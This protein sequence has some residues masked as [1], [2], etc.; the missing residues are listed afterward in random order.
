MPQ[1]FNKS[2]DTLNSKSFQG[3]LLKII[4]VPI[5]FLILVLSF[6]HFQN[7]YR[8]SLD[9]D[10]KTLDEAFLVTVNIEKSISDMEMALHGYAMTKNKEFL[11]SYNASYSNIQKEKEDI[12][13]LFDG[14]YDLTKELRVLLDSLADWKKEADYAIN[15]RKN[16][17]ASDERAEAKVEKLT[18]VQ[19]DRFKALQ[20]KVNTFKKFIRVERNKKVLNRQSNRDLTNLI[21]VIFV[22]LIAVVMSYFLSR[23]LK[24][25]LKGYRK[26]L[27]D[28]AKNLDDLEAASKS[29]DQFLANMSHEIRTPLGAILGFAELVSKKKNL[30][31]E[32]QGH[33]AFIRRNSEHLFG[34]IEDLFDL[35]KISVNKLEVA[36]EKVNLTELTN[37]L[38]NNFSSKVNDKKITLTIRADNRIPE[39]I[40]TDLLRLKQILSN[41]IGNA[42]KFSPNNS[43]IDVI[44]TYNDDNL[45]VDVID[46]G[47]GI[48]PSIQSQIFEAFTQADESH[49]RQFGGAG[50][51]LSISKELAH[52]LGGE[53]TLVSSQPKIG[54]HFRLKIPAKSLGEH[55]IEGGIEYETEAAAKDNAGDLNIDLSSAKILLA[56]DSKENQIL[57][58]I[59]LESA[60]PN[61]TIVDN[62]SDAVREAL[63]GDYDLVL[64][65]IQMPGLDGYEVLQILRSSHFSKKI[66]ALTAH[67]L[68]GEKERCLTAGFD[69]YLSKP[70]SQTKL[71]ATIK[72][73]LSF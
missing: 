51:G 65:D 49:T 37:D 4:T 11:D 30:D 47:I 73:N 38:R 5:L 44:F 41:L 64:L 34:L 69:D 67:A 27:S 19:T 21:E 18:V 12:F 56:E 48:D 59:F 25:L 32:T 40:E 50:L 43:N 72:G 54:S 66:V 7:K 68:K 52:L 46:Q 39:E 36:V 57:F 71:L 70:V 16:N 14:N 33:I 8:N 42:I 2:L 6:F 53:L 13:L 1:R 17:H 24:L 26:L 45:T 31:T 20:A 58:K 63:R 29:K 61:L 10:L 23:Q 9:K 22:F 60:H 62:G 35:S 3:H 28:Y 15:I 55:W